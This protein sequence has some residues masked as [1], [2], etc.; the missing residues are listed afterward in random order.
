[1][2]RNAAE[3]VEKS[4]LPDCEGGS[5][6]RLRST[7]QRSASSPTPMEWPE[8]YGETRSAK[9][10]IAPSTIKTLAVQRQLR[11][12]LDAR[13]SSQMR[14]SSSRARSSGVLRATRRYLRVER[15]PGALVHEVRCVVF[16]AEETLEAASAATWTIRIGKGIVALGAAQRSLAV[17]AFGQVSEQL[18]H[19]SRSSL[20]RPAFPRPR[21]QRKGPDLAPRVIRGSRRTVWATRT[22]WGRPGSGERAR[23]HL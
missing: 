14:P 1:M 15:L 10:P 5:R 19:R 2:N 18:G 22:C 8:R 3:V 9:L 23:T 17:P 7:E 12:R 13:T 6:H 11:K 4:C 16:A 21:S 20:R